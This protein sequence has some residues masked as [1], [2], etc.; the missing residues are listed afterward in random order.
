MRVIFNIIF[1][2]Y[3]TTFCYGQSDSAINKENKILI[4]WSP[5]SLIGYSAL[6][7]AGDFFYKPKKSIQ[8][9]YGIILTE[10]GLGRPDNRG[11]RIRIEQRN[12]L[13]KEENF[14]LAPELHFIFVQYNSTQR[15]SQ[16]WVTDSI[17]GERY[18]IDSYLDNVGIKKYAFSGNIKIGYQYIFKKPKIL[19]DIYFGL[20]IRYVI[21]RFTSY[22]AVGE[23]VPPKD[24]WF[25]NYDYKE[26]NRFAPNGVFGI[27]IGYQIK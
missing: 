19:F 15:F 12:Y 18:A 3:L 2:M 16:D 17:T 22:P 4:K 5:T 20:G 6:Q 25:D 13:N 8:I 24:N 11:H 1:L 26:S 21:T 14:Y 23:W 9:E 7:F 10:I 27:K